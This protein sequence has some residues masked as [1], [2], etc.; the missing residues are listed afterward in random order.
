MYQQK[1][2]T[3]LCTHLVYLEISFLYK[4]D[5]FLY[6]FCYFWCFLSIH[7]LFVLVVI[8]IF[9]L[10]KTQTIKMHLETN[11]YMCME[12]ILTKKFLCFF[13][14]TGVRQIILFV[15]VFFR[16]LLL[17]ILLKSRLFEIRNFIICPR[18]NQKKNLI[19]ITISNQILQA[20]TKKQPITF[21]HNRLCSK[22]LYW[23]YFFNQAETWVS[24]FFVLLQAK[25]NNKVS[26]IFIA[27]FFHDF[28][29]SSV[30][31]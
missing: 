16:F 12:K 29:P 4:D 8:Y 1:W 24:H 13:A 5:A 28:H 18:R 30:Y 31:L 10:K 21:Q 17:L 11:A 25:T 7:L 6:A 14:L 20:S 23:S 9:I 22:T 19:R 26:F 15:K 3:F 27:H 2:Y